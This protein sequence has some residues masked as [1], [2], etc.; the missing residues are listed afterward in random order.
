MPPLNYLAASANIRQLQVWSRILRNRDPRGQVESAAS[1]R[2][3]ARAF[4]RYVLRLRPIR[5]VEAAFTRCGR[6]KSDKCGRVNLANDIV[7]I[8]LQ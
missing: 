3:R 4:L 2:A 8:P 5:P 7:E 6:I 1:K